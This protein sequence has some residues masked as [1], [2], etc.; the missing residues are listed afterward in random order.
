M[1]RHYEKAWTD[2][3][4]RYKRSSQVVWASCVKEEAEEDTNID[5]QALG[6]NK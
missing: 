5:A 2:Q 3:G 1:V 6:S 4:D